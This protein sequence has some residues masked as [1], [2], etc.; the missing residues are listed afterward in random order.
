MAS[1]LHFLPPLLFL[2]CGN[3]QLTIMV[4]RVIVC[5]SAPFS[6]PIFS[7]WYWP[8][9]YIY[10]NFFSHSRR[11]LFSSS[12]TTHLHHHRVPRRSFILNLPH[13]H[14]SLP[15]NTLVFMVFSCSL[16]PRSSLTIHS[17]RY[18][19]TF[20]FTIPSLLHYC[21]HGLQLVILVI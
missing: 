16:W 4:I 11:A 21:A 5:L 3:G 12:L 19:L 8:R 14:S 15:N 1:L 18:S 9:R 2:P 10:I 7:G 20:H 13:L 17:L 6:P